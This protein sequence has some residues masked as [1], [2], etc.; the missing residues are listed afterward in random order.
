MST[1]DRLRRPS[2]RFGV[3]A[4]AVAAL[5]TGA[6]AAPSAQS[7]APAAQDPQCAEA[8]PVA[9][10]F[11][12]MPVRGMTVST[13]TEPEQFTGSVLGVLNDGIAPGIDMIMVRLTND[14]INGA[15]L[16]YDFSG[17]SGKA[18]VKW[19]GSRLEVKLP[20]FNE[21]TI[22]VEGNKLTATRAGEFV[23][24]WEKAN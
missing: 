12:D 22:V 11:R 5:T 13:G 17:K 1:R 7:A 24:H 20:L 6:V 18:P 21:P 2:R 3:L 10:L 14:E 9:S 8:F 15:G 23:D 4:V 19:D 16:K